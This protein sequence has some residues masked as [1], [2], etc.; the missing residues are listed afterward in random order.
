MGPARPPARRRLGGPGGRPAAAAVPA[1]RST[2]S[3]AAARAASRNSC[4]RRAGRGVEGESEA[5]GAGGGVGWG[6]W[7]GAILPTR[8]LRTAVA[9][10]ETP[11]LG[12]RRQLQPWRQQSRPPAAEPVLVRRRWWRLA[13]GRRRRARGLR[14]RRRRLRGPGWRQWPMQ[15]RWRPGRRHQ[16]RRGRWW[17]PGRRHL[18]RR[19][20]ERRRLGSASC[21]L[22]EQGKAPGCVLESAKV[23]GYLPLRSR[24]P[25]R[26]E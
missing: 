14:R 1:H 7:G 16:Q 8:A 25:G 18:Q 4:P 10:S 5:A 2:R 17:R 26:R 15:Q 11:P 12:P 22:P 9:R 19:R 13:R 24:R 20:L 21:P 3:R 6:G 23:C